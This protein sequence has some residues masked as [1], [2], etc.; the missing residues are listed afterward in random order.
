[1]SSAATG[2]RGQENDR[3]GRWGEGRQAG[4]VDGQCIRNRPH[5]GGVVKQ[6]ER[7]VR[8]TFERRIERHDI[9]DEP[10]RGSGVSIARVGAIVVGY[11]GDM[12]ERPPQ[13]RSHWVEEGCRWLTVSATGDVC[14]CGGGAEGQRVAPTLANRWLGWREQMGN[15]SNP[16]KNRSAW[17]QG[18]RR[19]NRGEASI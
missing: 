2:L 9:H 14:F 7:L 15:E 10:Q 19:S 12:T 5:W 13:K 8:Y 11:G 4:T 6:A 18:S 1:V 3:N 16:Y 17:K